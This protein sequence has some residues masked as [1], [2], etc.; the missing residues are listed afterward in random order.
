MLINLSLRYIH[1]RLQ[2][3]MTHASISAAMGISMPYCNY[4]VGRH[5]LRTVLSSIRSELEASKKSNKSK[6]LVYYT[7]VL[8]ND[9]KVFLIL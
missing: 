9:D 3:P 5:S 6:F 4:R 2:V 7:F 8:L 1:L